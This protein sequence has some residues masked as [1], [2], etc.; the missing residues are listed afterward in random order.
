MPNLII[1]S[2]TTY[3][4]IDNDIHAQILAYLKSICTANDKICKSVN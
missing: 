2:G 1:D 4:K 3:T